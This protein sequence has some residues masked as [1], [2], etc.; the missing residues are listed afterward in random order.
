[1]KYKKSCQT[2]RLLLFILLYL[3]KRYGNNGIFRLYSNTKTGITAGVID[4]WIGADITKR[5]I[6]RLEKM[7]IVTCEDVSNRYGKYKKIT[8]NMPDEEKAVCLFTVN[9][10]NPLIELYRYTKERK[11]KKCKVCSCYFIAI[12]NQK[13]CGSVLC[14]KKLQ[15]TTKGKHNKT[16]LEIS[17]EKNKNKKT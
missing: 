7:G 16:D 10:G 9:G 17:K 8:V 2:D 15:K 12:G 11:I 4:D 1:M 3:T 13:T 14:S 6:A 5:G